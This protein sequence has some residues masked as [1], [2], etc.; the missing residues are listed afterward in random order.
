MKIYLGIPQI[1]IT[2]LFLL[3]LGFHFAKNGEPREEEY[4][5]GV[6]LFSVILQIALLIWGGFYTIR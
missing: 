1:I 4:N 2:I 3:T 6:A 5:F